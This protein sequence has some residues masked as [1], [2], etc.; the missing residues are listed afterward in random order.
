MR[1]MPYRNVSLEALAISLSSLSIHRQIDARRSARR[2]R[3][4]YL[5]RKTRGKFDNSPAFA[6]LWRLVEEDADAEAEDM[7][8]SCASGYTLKKTEKREP[9]F[10]YDAGAGGVAANVSA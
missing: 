3:I 6:K 9:N 2:A 5:Q 7:R 8:N 10:D 4:R 1:P